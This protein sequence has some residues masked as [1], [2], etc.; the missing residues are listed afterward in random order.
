[1]KT[2]GLVPETWKLTKSS[3]A[4]NRKTSHVEVDE[5]RRNLHVGH[6]EKYE[7]VQDC[8]KYEDANEICRK[9]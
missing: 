7:L 6:V 1:M 5:V 8:T 2:W 9:R 3:K 4:V